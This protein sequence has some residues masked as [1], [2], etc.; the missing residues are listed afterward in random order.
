M[1]RNWG[2]CVRA[3]G[4]RLVVPLGPATRV[5]WWRPVLAVM[6]A[7]LFLCEGC[8]PDLDRWYLTLHCDDGAHT[9]ECYTRENCRALSDAVI[10]INTACPSGSIGHKDAGND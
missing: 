8:S 9:V 7:L 3:D 4:A 2:I 1:L 5:R 10:R 6:F